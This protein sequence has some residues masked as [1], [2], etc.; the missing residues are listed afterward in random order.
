MEGLLEAAMA[1]QNLTLAS[2]TTRRSGDISAFASTLQVQLPS[3][4]SSL[5]YLYL[6]TILPCNV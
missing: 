2:K 4:F 3:L 5:R 1:L 6:S